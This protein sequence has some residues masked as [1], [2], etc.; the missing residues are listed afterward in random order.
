VAGQQEVMPGSG[1]GV[2]CRAEV[3][4][5]AVVGLEFGKG[6]HEAIDVSISSVGHDIDIEGC[7]GSALDDRRHASDQEEAHPVPVQRRQDRGEVSRASRHAGP[8]S[9]S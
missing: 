6:V 2:R 7:K 5:L 9:P 1:K 3:G 4:P 8:R